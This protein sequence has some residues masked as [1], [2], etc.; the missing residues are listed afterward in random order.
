MN[1]PDSSGQT[2]MNIIMANSPD[3]SGQAMWQLKN[4][5]IY[6]D[7]NKSSKIIREK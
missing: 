4:K 3:R 1:H 6:T 2:G 5:T 7:E